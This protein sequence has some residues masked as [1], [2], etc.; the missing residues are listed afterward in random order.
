MKPKVCS[1]KSQQNKKSIDKSK[2]KSVNTKFNKIRK[3]RLNFISKLTGRKKKDYKENNENL[4]D[5]ELENFG[6]INIFLERHKIP[7]LTQETVENLNRPITNIMV[8]LGNKI[9]QKVQAHT[10]THVNSNYTT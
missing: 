10:V 3:E 7:K 2:K 9:I 5:N 8:E 4:Y 1:L 6:E